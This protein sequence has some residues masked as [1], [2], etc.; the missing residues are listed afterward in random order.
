M[1]I[2]CRCVSPKITE[3]LSDRYTIISI[4]EGWLSSDSNAKVLGTLLVFLK[5]YPKDHSIRIARSTGLIS[6]QNRVSGGWAWIFAF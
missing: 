2:H 6:L 5:V 1:N 4:S 3:E